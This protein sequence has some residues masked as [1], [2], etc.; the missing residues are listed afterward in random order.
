MTLA[1][2]PTATELS[3]MSV[4]TKDAAPTVAFLP[5]VTPGNTTVWEPTRAPSK[6]VTFPYLLSIVEF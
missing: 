2:V 3:G 5:I 4:V 6:I 1:G